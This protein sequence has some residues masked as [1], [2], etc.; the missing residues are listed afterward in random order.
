M[1]GRV[2]LVIKVGCLFASIL[3]AAGC[4]KAPTPDRVQ[5]E[6]TP[7]RSEKMLSHP[8]SQSTNQVKIVEANW[9]N[10]FGVEDMAGIDNKSPKDLFD[11]AL[12]LEEAQW[13]SNHGFLS[14]SHRVRLSQL[15][16][17]EIGKMISIG[18]AH[19]TLFA[20]ENLIARGR[21]DLAVVSLTRLASDRS[22]IPARYLLSR[23]YADLL[24]AYD[25]S[26]EE[27]LSLANHETR[28][29]NERA[30]ERAAVELMRNYVQG[31][32][33]AGQMLYDLYRRGVSIP[34][35]IFSQTMTNAGRENSIRASSS[36]AS[37]GRFEPRPV[38]KGLHGLNYFP[39]VQGK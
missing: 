21:G 17:S 29:S 18:D 12:T 9:E 1:K 14:R 34:P 39:D 22:S 16:E 5:G 10:E 25:L 28:I 26:D 2:G 32:Y 15:S 8:A 31:D 6:E 33:R 13:L 23:Y 36:S 19:A 38:P 4:D 27:A 24:S 7:R 37:I 11:E 30:R 35:V 3:I 20:A